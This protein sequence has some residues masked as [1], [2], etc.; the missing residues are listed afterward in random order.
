MKPL[1]IL[2]AANGPCLCILCVSRWLTL[3]MKT[4]LDEMEVRLGARAEPTHQIDPVTQK[5]KILWMTITDELYLPNLTKHASM[6]PDLWYRGRNLLRG[7]DA[8]KRRD[9]RRTRRNKVSVIVSQAWRACDTQ[10]DRGRNVL[11]GTQEL[12]LTSPKRS[13]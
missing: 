4:S 5:T 12:R 11:D 10:K 3:D 13:V 6:T 1:V 8:E 9:G 7:K 2:L